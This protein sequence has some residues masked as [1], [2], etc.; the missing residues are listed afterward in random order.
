MDLTCKNMKHLWFFL[1]LVAAPR[2]VPSQVQLQESGPSLVKASKASPSPVLSPV[3]PSPVFLLEL[4]R[5]PP[6]KELE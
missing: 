2:C 4:D 3:T 6:G 5:Q 1:S